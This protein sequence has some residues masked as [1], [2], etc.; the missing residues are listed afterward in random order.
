MNLNISE[1]WLRRMATLEDDCEVAAGGSSHTSVAGGP[2][3]I[4]TCVV[5][6]M[7]VRVRYFEGGTTKARRFGSRCRAK[8]FV[9]HLLRCRRVGDGP[10]WGAPV[11]ARVSAEQPRWHK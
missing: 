4:L 10:A 2:N 5:P 3:A 8:R 9:R 11:D 7:G 1:E 6:G